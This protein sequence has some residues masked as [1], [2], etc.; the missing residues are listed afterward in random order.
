MGKS[1]LRNLRRSA[2]SQD[3]EYFEDYDKNDDGTLNVLDAQAWAQAGRRD[4]AQRVARMIG[5]GNMPVKK[6]DLTRAQRQRRNKI[7]GVPRRRWMKMNPRQRRAQTKVFDRS[8]RARRD[9]R[10][11]Q[12]RMYRGAT[13]LG[14]MPTRAERGR[15]ARTSERM[16]RK[17]ERG[18]RRWRIRKMGR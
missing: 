6:A 5:S 1:G 9:N 16:F 4:I 17:L 14:D 7:Y 10:R 8:W 11:R 18:R 3:P 13:S 12:L 2:K 15:L